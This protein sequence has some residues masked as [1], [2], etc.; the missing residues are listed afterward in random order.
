VT[1]QNGSLYYFSW[2]SEKYKI[3]DQDKI[4]FVTFSVAQWI[5]VFTRSVYKE[6]LIET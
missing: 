1:L 3:R 6:I 5:D 4:Y 2:V